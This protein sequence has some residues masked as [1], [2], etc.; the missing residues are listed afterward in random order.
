MRYKT[1]QERGETKKRKDTNPPQTTTKEYRFKHTN[2]KK[3][4]T[5]EKCDPMKLELSLSLS[6]IQNAPQRKAWSQGGRES[7][8]TAPHTC[9]RPRIPFGHILIE[10]RCLIK[11]CKREGCNS[12]KERPNHHKQQKEC[13][14]NNTKSKRTKRVRIV[15]R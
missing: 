6:Y 9:H 4:N 8:L 3:N 13:R 2:N 10:R 7:T 14:F 15:I 1:L 12:K 11:H 5:C